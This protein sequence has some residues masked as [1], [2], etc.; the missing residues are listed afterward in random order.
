MLANVKENASWAQ[1]WFMPG[2][3]PERQH[4]FKTFW[5]VDGR[6]SNPLR[7]DTEIE[8]LPAQPFDVE[9]IYSQWLAK[10]QSPVNQSFNHDTFKSTCD[11]FVSKS[12]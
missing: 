7:D 5:R 12:D 9:R 1:A 2:V 3:H 6:A 8:F 10:Q 11:K 4:L